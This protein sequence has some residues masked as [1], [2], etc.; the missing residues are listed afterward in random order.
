MFHFSA[1]FIVAMNNG[2][3]SSTQTSLQSKEKVTKH[4]FQTLQRANTDFVIDM[5]MEF[6]QNYYIIYY[7]RARGFDYLLPAREIDGVKLFKK[8]N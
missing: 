5:F 4:N 8:R 1:L 6:E 7:A 3:F 2:N